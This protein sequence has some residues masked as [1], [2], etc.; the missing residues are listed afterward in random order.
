MGKKLIRNGNDFGLMYDDCFYPVIRDPHSLKLYVYIDIDSNPV[1]K[2]EYNEDI[3]NDL[4]F[5]LLHIQHKKWMQD[6][7][8]K[9]MEKRKL[10]KFKYNIK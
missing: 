10:N 8:K 2:R 1:R 7:Y 3:E 5:K 4:I 6:K 9:K